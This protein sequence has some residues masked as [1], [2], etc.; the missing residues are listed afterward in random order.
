[1]KPITR[2]TL[3]CDRSLPKV[4]VR[5]RGRNRRLLPRLR[6]LCRVARRRNAGAAIR[7]LLD[8]VT[9]RRGKRWRPV[10]NDD[11]YGRESGTTRSIQR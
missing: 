6:R 1:M 5:S 9:F 4:R 10:P 8:G 3:S 7:W 11:P 2:L